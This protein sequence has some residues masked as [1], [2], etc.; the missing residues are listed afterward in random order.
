MGHIGRVV[1]HP[2]EATLMEATLT[3]EGLPEK[4]KLMRG[5]FK[6]VRK[7]KKSQRTEQDRTDLALIQAF[8][9]E[10]RNKPRL[11]WVGAGSMEMGRALPTGR[12][13]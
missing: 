1:D 6:V 5:N 8:S 12:L 3:Q 10:K 9:P 7:K 13:S 4:K 2:E 11:A